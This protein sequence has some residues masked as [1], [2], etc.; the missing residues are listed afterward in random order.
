MSDPKDKVRRSRV[1]KRVQVTDNIF[2]S[3]RAEEITVYKVINVK[4]K[5]TPVYTLDADEW[6]RVLPVLEKV[7][8]RYL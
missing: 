7:V 6:H 3:I 2:I 4:N 8:N 5:P 1:L